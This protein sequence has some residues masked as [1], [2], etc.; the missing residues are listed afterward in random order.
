MKELFKQIGLLIIGCV[1]FLIVF[2][3]GFLYTTGKHFYKLDYSFS[4]QLTPIVRSIT[5]IFDGLANAGAGELLND[6]YKIDGTIKYGNWYQT[7]SAVT[8]LIF[9]NVKDT[10]L[11]RF[12]DK[13]LGKDHCVTAIKN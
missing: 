4:K 7:I 12:L 13:V 11:R 1:V 5:L 8:G 3:V 6:V 2:I 10:G 9:I